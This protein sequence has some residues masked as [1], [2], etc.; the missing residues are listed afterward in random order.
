MGISVQTLRNYS[1]GLL[2]SP[3]YINEETNYRFYSFDQFHIIDRI[4]YLRGFGLSLNE[5]EKIMYS[6]DNV[7][8]IVFFLEKQKE[9][10]I[11][12]IKE[13][14][15]T[16]QDISWYINYF[17]YLNGSENNSF[18][19]ISHFDTRKILVTECEPEQSIENIEVKLTAMKTNLQNAGFRFHRQFGYLL[20]YNSIINKDWLPNKY[21]IFI[22]DLPESIPEEYSKNI[23]TVLAGDYFCLSFRLRHI[24]D[25]NTSLILEYFKL[26]P[27]PP[28]VIANEHEDNIS[29]YTHCPYELQFYLGEQNNS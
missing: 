26:K 21:Y 12:Q 15:I 16:I 6:G 18:P 11:K 3:A 19:H 8:D 10:V 1:N 28:Y 4:K 13:L 25:L 23:V 22:S 27:N 2:L 24:T 5:I 14:N 17:K 29:I 9:Q 7:K 20:D